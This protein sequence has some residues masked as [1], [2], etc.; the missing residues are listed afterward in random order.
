MNLARLW[1]EEEIQ[2]VKD[3][4][5]VQD[6]I[7]YSSLINSLFSGFQSQTGVTETALA[8][9]AAIAGGVLAAIT[10]VGAIVS[11]PAVLSVIDTAIDVDDWYENYKEKWQNDPDNTDWYTDDIKRKNNIKL[12]DALCYGSDLSNYIEK[13]SG[14]SLS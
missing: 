2:A 4:L 11:I 12:G 10:A 8:L 9:P 5:E 3:A 13:N 14:G 7:D 1:K 6:E